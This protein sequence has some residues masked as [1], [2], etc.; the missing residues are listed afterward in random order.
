MH[1]QN[2]F[3]EIR[4]R[5][6]RRWFSSPQ[7]DLILWLDRQRRLKGFELCYDK[8]DRERSLSWTPRRGFQ[9]MAVDSGENR[10]GKHK[11]SP[12]LVPDGVFDAERVR[13]DFLTASVSLP[14][15]IAAYVRMALQQYTLP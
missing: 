15:E 8:Q 7:F 13:Q 6:D 9:H 1:S 2:D 14:P 5:A 11:S 3:Q 12:I 4:G 10:P